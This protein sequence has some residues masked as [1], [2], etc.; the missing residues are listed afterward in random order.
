MKSCIRQC[1]ETNAKVKPM[2]RQVERVVAD[3]QLYFHLRVFLEKCAK[4]RTDVTASEAQRCVDADQAFWLSLAAVDQL[5][6]L[7]DLRQD[8]GRVGK[9]QFTF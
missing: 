7:I 2:G 9:K 8:P 1:A 6:D 4:G 3:L 5:L